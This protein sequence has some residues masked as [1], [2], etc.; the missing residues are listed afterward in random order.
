IIVPSGTYLAGARRIGFQN[1]STGNFTITVKLSN[2]A[3]GSTGTGVVLPQGTA[4]N[5]ST[6]LYTDGVNDIWIEDAGLAPVYT[7]AGVVI[8][9]THS[10]QGTAT[11]AGGTVTITLT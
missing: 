4:N 9:R 6:L 7:A 2:G 10:V 3:G 1:N 8:G 5:T 11:L